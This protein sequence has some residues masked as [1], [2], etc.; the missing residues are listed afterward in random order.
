MNT[1]QQDAGSSEDQR[2]KTSV[3]VLLI[4]LALMIVAALF[5]LN[6]LTGPWTD[7]GKTKVAF[8][9]DMNEALSSLFTS[10]TDTQLAIRAISEALNQAGATSN[11]QFNHAF[12]SVSQ[13]FSAQWAPKMLESAS[14]IGRA[15]AE[16]NELYR[17][18]V[19]TSENLRTVDAI[20]DQIIRN[21]A[22]HDAMAAGQ[23]DGA[24]Y[25]QWLS[26]STDFFSKMDR[27]RTELEIH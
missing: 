14:A 24:I 8:K 3:V 20:K 19:L 11:E 4:F 7:A 22:F 12:K 10:Y 17:F 23:V 13:Q 16:A 26:D 27:I 9:S 15:E 6:R 2:G 5:V 1:S 25:R 21:G 18:H